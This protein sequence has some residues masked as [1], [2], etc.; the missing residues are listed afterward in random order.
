MVIKTSKGNRQR[1]SLYL[2]T[3]LYARIKK[4]KFEKKYSMNEKACVLLERSLDAIE[5]SE[6][7]F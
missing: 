7:K 6:R 2:D 4:V 5:Q 1:L 3:V